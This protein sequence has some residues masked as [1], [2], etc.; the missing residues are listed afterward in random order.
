MPPGPTKPASVPDADAK[1]TGKRK[2]RSLPEEN[3]R[4]K[5]RGC[6]K[7]SRWRNELRREKEARFGP[8]DRA[9]KLAPCESAPTS[10]ARQRCGS[11]R[12]SKDRPPVRQ[13]LTAPK[14]EN[15]SMAC[16]AGQ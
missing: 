16:R 6:E 9:A 3:S 11:G 10:L 2:Q 1:S 13:A 5:R 7:W 14:S 4:P 15:H 12:A 8:S